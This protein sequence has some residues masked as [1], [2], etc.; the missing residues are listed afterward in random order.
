MPAARVQGH[1]LHRVLDHQVEFTSGRI[2]AAGRWHRRSLGPG[3]QRWWQTWTVVAVALELDA[4]GHS[5]GELC[6]KL[7]D[8]ERAQAALRPVPGDAQ[9]TDRVR[10]GVGAGLIVPWLQVDQHNDVGPNARTRL[11]QAAATLLLALH[12]NSGTQCTDALAGETAR[13]LARLAGAATPATDRDRALLAT[14]TL[15][16]LAYRGLVDDLADLT[17]SVPLGYLQSAW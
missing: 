14:V 17:S 9:A 12:Q 15:A 16:R 13:V 6:R 11:R 1:R 5:G 2:T 7:L 8:P 4:R 10:I 3:E